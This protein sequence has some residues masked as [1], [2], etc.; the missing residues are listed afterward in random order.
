MMKIPMCGAAVLAALALP[1]QAHVSVTPVS[2]PAGGHVRLAFG[3]THGCQGSATTEV[4]LRLPHERVLNARP[5]PKPGWTLEIERRVLAA[6]YELHGRRV[7]D[8]VAE[9]RWR[10]GPLPNAHYD[11]FVIAA[12]LADGA[13]GPVAFEL[14][15]QCERGRNEWVG[16][17]G[18][19]SPAPV[20]NVEP[21]AASGHHGH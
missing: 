2:A 6:P 12:K 8:S 5:M 4:I 15:Q 14:L 11:E 18:S 13:A 10:G 9:I 19:E 7:A 3:V 17:P 1:A 20:L 21:A 16:A